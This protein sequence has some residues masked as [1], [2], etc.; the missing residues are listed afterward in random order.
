MD[1]L[2]IFASLA[3]ASAA[4]VPVVTF[5]GTLLSYFK[6][7]LKGQWEQ[8]ISWLAAFGIALVGG[9]QDLGMFADMT[10]YWQL[11]AGLVIGLAANGVYDIAILKS[12]FDFLR[13]V[14]GREGK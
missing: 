5:A 9:W 4:V 6:I 3:A 7:D 12:I 11:A 2:E 8:I 14:F 1:Y 13:S 10:I